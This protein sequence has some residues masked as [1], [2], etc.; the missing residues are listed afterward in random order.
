M[1][2]SD[3]ATNL[4]KWG[5]SDDQLSDLIDKVNDQFDEIFSIFYPNFK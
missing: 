4:S 1:E 2:L 3:E 5:I